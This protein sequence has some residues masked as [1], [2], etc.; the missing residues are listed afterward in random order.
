LAF[1]GILNSIIGLYYYLVV[2]KRV[3]LY[4]SEKEDQPIIISRPYRIALTVLSLGILLLGAFF[5]P[6]F[7]WSS[8]AAAGLF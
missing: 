6:W 2:L 3:Y 4:R 7:T 1:V 8:G 5:A